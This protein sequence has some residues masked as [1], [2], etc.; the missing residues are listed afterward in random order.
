MHKITSEELS[1]FE[2]ELNQFYFRGIPVGSLIGSHLNIDFLYGHFHPKDYLREMAMF[3]YLKC[4]PG[5]QIKG[6]DFRK[7]A[8]SK[9]LPI[10]TFVSE[11]R[12]L[13]NMSYPVY[14]ELGHENVFCL[15]KNEQVLSLFKTQPKHYALFNEL[16]DYKFRIWRKDFKIMW[17]EIEATV[18]KFIIGY[19]INSN[20]R[21]RLYNNLLGETR[22]IIS[23]ELLLDFLKPEYILTH[24][25][26]YSF[27]A[28]LCSM[29]KKLSIPSF[30]MTHGVISN[31]IGFTPLVAN[32]VFAWGERQR[33]AFINYG[34]N[35]NQIVITGAPQLSNEI[36]G[37]K[38]QLKTTLGIPPKAIVVLLATNPTQN[39]LRIKLFAIF[40]K[41]IE[42][43]PRNQYYGFLKIHP[44]EDMN[45]YTTFEN[46]P[47]NMILDT[48]KVISF[49]D[50]F[51]LTDVVCN[52]NSAYAIDAL[53]RGLPLITINVNDDN[54]GQAKDFIDFGQLPVVS[55]SNELVSLIEAYFNDDIF[56]EKLINNVHAYA[57][58][59]C[60][61]FGSNAVNN[62]ILS[63]END[64]K[65]KQEIL[66]T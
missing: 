41:A 55:N 14:E 40:C 24:Y 6:F 13:F 20:Y 28:A 1:R 52:Y 31:S 16:P 38:L 56:A 39:D 46:R 25:D 35:D 3:Y 2:L 32:K 26:R 27:T 12:H 51:A 29:A 17:K 44:S 62:I 43:L 63:I 42:S 47:S 36:K 11:R 4:F 18:K 19:S 21:L 23:F 5:R 65:E 30:T 57:K 54:L 15:I 60:Y 49:E 34:L 8:K 10:I 22:Y 61:S 59:Y 48:N 45:F 58:A 50:S 64:V 33:K 7:H 53:L 37:D 9:G 66:K